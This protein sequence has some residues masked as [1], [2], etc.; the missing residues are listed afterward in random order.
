MSPIGTN[1]LGLGKA[2][3]SEFNR[4]FEIINLQSFNP[5]SLNLQ[6]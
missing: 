1:A 2:V 3:V 5:Q 6:S 4:L